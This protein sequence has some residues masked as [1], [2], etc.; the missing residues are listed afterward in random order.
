MWHALKRHGVDIGREQTR[1]LMRLAG[2][3][4]KGKER[5]PVTTS[6]AQA[7]ET[8]PDLVQRQ[9]KTSA[10]NRLWVGY[11]LRT[12]RTLKLVLVSSTRLLLPTF[13]KEN[14]GMGFIEL[15]AGRSSALAGVE[16]SNP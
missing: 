10:P 3:C 12:S 9:F 14:C 2:V 11:G 15:D 7:P 13:F 6:K 4:G 8:R 5:S 16:S 1:R